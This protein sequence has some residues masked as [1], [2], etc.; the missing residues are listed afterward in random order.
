MQNMATCIVCLSPSSAA[1]LLHASFSGNATCARS[2]LLGST[3]PTSK[4]NRS[5]TVHTER[6]DKSMMAGR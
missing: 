3:H 2:L 5:H 4:C 1:L 6:R